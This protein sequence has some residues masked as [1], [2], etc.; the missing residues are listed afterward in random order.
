MQ[1]DTTALGESD[2]VLLLTKAIQEWQFPDDASPQER[3]EVDQARTLFR[4]QKTELK[5]SPLLNLIVRAEQID[6]AIDQAADKVS[7]PIF[8]D[9][10]CAAALVAR[11]RILTN[12]VRVERLNVYAGLKILAVNIPSQERDE[13]E[14]DLL[15]TS[16]AEINDLLSFMQ[17]SH[18]IHSAQAAQ[19]R[20]NWTTSDHLIGT[21]DY[22][23][24]A[25]DE[26]L[27]MRISQTIEQKVHRRFHN[28]GF[29][30]HRLWR[31]SEETVTLR[32]QFNLS[33]YPFDKHNIFLQLSSVADADPSEL[34]LHPDG[35]DIGMAQGPRG[36]TVNWGRCNLEP[37]AKFIATD[38]I[39]SSLV[40]YTFLIRRHSRAFLWRTFVPTLVIVFLSLSAT[41]FA[42]NSGQ[43]IEAVLTQVIP[44]ALIACVALQL[45]ASHSIPT[46]AGRT[47]IDLFF[48]ALYIDILLLYL[49][50]QLASTVLAFWLLIPAI[51]VF[52]S[53]ATYYSYRIWQ[54]RRLD[55]AGK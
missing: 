11:Q 18:L 8:T 26:C 34:I 3:Q 32:M 42:A 12:T 47:H 4:Q 22:E 46:G 52:V 49:V 37:V 29:I 19:L 33:Q 30:S 38:Y 48:V 14:I 54:S 1:A 23:Q 7:Y 41:V 28:Y 35:F 44:A 10:D 40:R 9:V 17:K 6:W 39:A 2:I 36:F 43:F 24:R 27:G 20:E 55:K 45:T 50:L 15:V 53:A 13:V 31:I 5:L 25:I 21:S 16:G 51:G